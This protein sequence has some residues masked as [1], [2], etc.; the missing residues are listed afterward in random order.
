MSVLRL[1]LGCGDKP[2]QGWTNVDIRDLPGVDIV[3]D[4][5]RLPWPFDSGDV[6][7]ILMDNVLE[8]LASRDAIRVLNEIGRVLKLGGQATIIVPHALSQGAYQDPTHVSFWVPRSALY[9][10]Q[11]QTPFGGK[12][13]GI[14]ADLMP[15]VE[16]EISGDMRTEAFI[17]F[18]VYR[19][20]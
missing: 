4:L 12:A 5:R 20:S 6:D 8:H 15:L 19:A 2:L 13:V 9:W 16:P 10:N 11:Q 18:R 7:E 14:T 3:Y 1:N 17:T